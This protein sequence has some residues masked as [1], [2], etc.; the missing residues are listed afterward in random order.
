M[1]K[2]A[3]YNCNSIRKNVEI[4]KNLCDNNDIVVLQELML[5]QRDLD[6][7][8]SINIDFDYAA[9]T[10]D[11]Y[12]EGIDLGRP[13][14]GVCIMW[15]KVISHSIEPIYINERIIAIN[16]LTNVGKVLI[17]NC[18]LPCD[19]NTC[20]SMD[21]FRCS[22]AILENY[23][24]ESCVNNVILVG[25]FNSDPN[26]GRFWRELNAFLERNGLYHDVGLLS[27]DTFTYLSPSSNTTSW[28]D[29]IVCNKNIYDKIIK[30]YVDHNLALYDHFPLEISLDLKIPAFKDKPIIKNNI[31]VKK[32]V[33]WNKMTSSQKAKFSSDVNILI[34]EMIDRHGVLN[35][36]CKIICND[37]FHKDQLDLIFNEIIDILLTSSTE[38]TMKN[39][40]FPRN[41]PGWNDYIK[42]AYK[43]AREHFKLWRDGGKPLEGQLLNDM[44]NSRTNFKRILN[45]CKRNEDSLRNEK[46]AQSYFDKDNSKFWRLTRARIK[47]KS[48]GAA[49]IDGQKQPGDV[50]AIFS[51][52]FSQIFADC[53]SSKSKACS[54]HGN[55][56]NL[57][58]DNEYIFT[59]N[60]I[61]KS[62]GKLKSN[63]GPD[64]I[65]TNHLKLCSNNIS[66][67]LAKLFSLFLSH[68]YIPRR[69][70]EGIIT[71][72]IK[73]KFG[74]CNSSS[75]YRP[76][77][78]SSVFLK[79]FEYCILDKIN[80]FLHTNDRQHGF[81]PRYST[82]TACFVLKET[83]SGY[84]NKNSSVYAAFLDISKAFDKI[85]H[86]KLF[87]KLKKRNVP[88]I[89]TKIISYWYSNQ[90]IRVR[91][92]DVFSEEW[93]IL[94]GVRQ[95]GILSSFFFNIYINDLI[96]RISKCGYGCKLGIIPSN[97]IG[98]ADDIVILALSISTLQ[99]LI[100]LIELEIC[101]LKLQ[102]NTEKTVCIKFTKNKNKCL[103][104]D[105]LI[106]YGN[107]YLKFVEEIKYL[108][109]IINYNLNDKSD[110][111]KVRNTFYSQFNLILRKFYNV[112]IEINLKL[113]SSYCLQFYGPSLWCNTHNNNSLLRQ[114]GVGYHKAIKKIF[115]VPMRSSNH[116]ICELAGLLNFNHLLNL[117]KINFIFRIF[118]RP[119]TFLSKSSKFLLKNSVLKHQVDNILLNTYDI[120]DIFYNDIDAITSRVF[121]VNRH[122]P[123][124]NY[125][126][127]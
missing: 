7:I 2:L 16:L 62:I 38:Y 24:K 30:L 47:S 71:P 54:D 79:I 117:T 46:L 45:F 110:I 12:C 126:Y 125:G 102:I 61:V 96:N 111:I 51:N 78:I 39:N 105:N 119:C 127:G 6:Y 74:N 114:F 23:I 75:N 57:S 68:S 25:D 72:I 80:I 10:K 26:K 90:Y 37:R 15:R 42:E 118:N 11:K 86:E 120:E 85:N 32:F 112:N 89:F 97:I 29:H 19:D 67:V 34:K 76:I 83:V 122:E 65:H 92:S 4:V 9:F 36:N 64:N 22:I 106:K 53:T 21:E 101:N 20:N 121:Y 100:N 49:I 41:I 63:V 94:N 103:L 52:K 31:D 73:D 95:G 116:I 69:M 56:N 109:F 66:Y 81:K 108:G 17:L 93:K 113:F 55:T 98:Y 8:N 14:R 50:A 87:D 1:L 107:N 82:Q 123:S 91:Y 5:L 115:N 35:C 40:N 70:A 44:K 27:Q 13:A 84:L 58:S 124:S 18:Y 28:L 43:I 48:S 88:S 99:Y 3:S 60:D 59:K 33:A 104:N 77:I